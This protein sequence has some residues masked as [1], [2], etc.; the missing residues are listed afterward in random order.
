M[1]WLVGQRP[2]RVRGGGAS[3]HGNGK[4]KGE[5]GRDFRGA[6]R[7]PPE[8]EVSNRDW[9]HT[10]GLGKRDAGAVERRGLERGAEGTPEH[11]PLACL[12]APTPPPFRM[13][14]GINLST[15][16]LVRRNIRLS[17][18]FFRLL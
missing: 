11:P 1:A 3:A 5:T 13:A 12:A 18:L 8:A 17:L 6:V 10:V 14:Y 4:G 16:F 7:L 2:P 15:V 9:G